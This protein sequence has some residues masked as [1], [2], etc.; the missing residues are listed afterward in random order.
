MDA[1]DTTRRRKNRTLFAD[2]V[3]QTAAFEKGLRNRIVLEGGVHTGLGASTYNPRFYAVEEGALVTTAAERDA[4]IAAVPNTLPNPPTNVSAVAGDSQTTITFSPSVLPSTAPTLSY[5]VTST[6][7]NVTATGSASPIVVTGLTNGVSYRFRVTARNVNGVSTPSAASNAVTPATSGTVPDA[8]TS[9]SVVASSGGS[10]YIYFTPSFDGGAPITDYEYSIDNGSTWESAEG[11]ESP[12]FISSGLS[13]GTVYTVRLRAVNS[14]GAGAQ[15]DSVSVASLGAFEPYTISGSMNVWLDAQTSGTIIK[16]G[17]IVTAWGDKSSGNNTFTA[18]G[19]GTIAYDVPSGINSRPA[20][21]F[22]AIATYLAKDSFNIAPS[23]QLTVFM[24]VRQTG[25]GTGNSELFFTRNNYLYFDIFNRTNSDGILCMNIGQATQNSTNVDILTSPPT[26]AI[27]SMVADTTA[28]IYVNGATTSVNGVARGGLSLNDATLDWTISG[29]A[30]LGNV[31]EVICFTTPLN[32]VQRQAMEGYLAWKWGLQGSLAAGHPYLS[33][34]PALV[35]PSAPSDLVATAG[36]QSASIAF[37]ANFDGGT[38]ITNYLYSIDDGETYTAF[39]PAQTSSPVSITGLT[40]GTTYTITLKAVTALGTSTS[41]DSVSV[42]PAVVISGSPNVLIIGDA[43]AT[44]FAT[45]LQSAKTDM[46]YVG[47]ITITTKNVYSAPTSDAGYTGT[48][49][50]SYDVVVL[51]TNGGLTPQT[52]LGT[53]LNAYVSGGG[54]LIMGVF[55]WGNVTAFPGLAYTDSSTYNHIGTQSSTGSPIT[56]VVSHP[57]LSGINGTIA[58]S[59]SYT[60]NVTLTSPSTSPPSLPTTIATYAD[61]TSFIA[62]RTFG[63]AKLVGINTYPA[64][65]RWTGGDSQ[66]N[67][68]RYYLNAIYWSIG[69]LV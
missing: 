46:G 60:A 5:T 17:N 16:S 51:Y 62:V 4:L 29:G 48:D 31:G 36:D 19:T 26:N 13:L 12:V 28:F 55:A 56:T 3:V 15:S 47:T 43:S 65:A 49:L 38:P 20:L 2:R 27:I 41:S 67:L 34:P 33:A 35:F 1:S 57:I 69:S 42:T 64:G 39:S 58:I 11:T 9:L 53:N 6:P 63:S 54:K 66:R 61:A 18:G 14:V 45:A 44:D 21:N 40:N 30:F 23:N 7:G 32:T 24:V 37:I 10:A 52:A 68:L 25:N 59:G 8:P 22:G 50:A